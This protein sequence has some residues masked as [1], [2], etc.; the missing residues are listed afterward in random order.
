MEF[1]GME[2]AAIVVDRVAAAGV[3]ASDRG[4]ERQQR[5]A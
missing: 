4:R 1:R 3:W 2:K 5:L